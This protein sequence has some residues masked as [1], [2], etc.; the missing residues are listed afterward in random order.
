MRIFITGASGFI[1]SHL[2]DRLLAEENDVLVLL[3]DPSSSW[4]L[5]NVLSRIH[6]TVGR[7]N[8]MNVALGEVRRFAPDVIYHLGW[9]GAG[10]Y[11][12]QYN[13]EQVMANIH[14]SLSL[15]QCAADV[16]SVLIGLGSV[17]E[18][19][20]YPVPLGEQVLPSPVTLYGKAKYAVGLLSEGISSHTNVRV[21]WFRLFWAYGP[22]DQGV[23]LIPSVILSL[24]RG[25]K[26][27][28]SPG[29]QRW[30]YL[31]VDDVID[32]LWL[33]AKTGNVKGVYNL[34]SG[35]SNSIRDVVG[36]IRNAVNPAAQL[37]FGGVP[38][39]PDQ[40][41]HLKADISRITR[42]LQWSPRVL[43]A[44]GIQ[45]TVRWFRENGG[46]YQVGGPLLEGT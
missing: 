17:L 36:L 31:Y 42:D 35:E 45:R 11:S 38:Y 34:G 37:E 8:D 27:L 40:I 6:I 14:G 5:S 16:G 9:Q 12:Q 2:V 29:A 4:R 26:P 43:L 33:A 1:G 39:R 25:Q 41:M 21:C 7:L 22:R 19:G 15:L 23:R 10:S 13:A 18:Y 20:V 44:D 3:R 28:L 24:L 32:A 46:Y 30:D